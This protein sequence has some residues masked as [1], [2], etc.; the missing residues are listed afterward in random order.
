[1]IESGYEVRRILPGNRH[2][3]EQLDALLAKEGISR[4]GNLE[5]TIGLYDADGRLVATGSVFKNTLRCMAVDSNHQG[6]GLLNRVTSLLVEYQANRE[7][8]ELFLYTKCSTAKFFGDLGFFE[9]CRVSDQVV[10]MENRRNGFSDY[11]SKL[12]EPGAGPRRSAIIMNANPFTL[13]HRHLVERASAESDTVHLF[14]VS[15][16]ASLVPAKVRY[17]LVKEGVGDLPNVVLH[18]TGPYMI[19]SATFP[20]YFIRD[21]RDIILA[22]ARLDIQVFAHIA[23]KL[24]ITARYVGEEPFSEL[25]GLYN[26]VMRQELT[27]AGIDCVI[28]PRKEQ[29]GEAIS[30]STVRQYIQRGELERLSAMVPESTLRYFSSPEG[31]ETVVRIRQ[32]ENVVHY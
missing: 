20:S 4:D 15:E 32:A 1:M 28:I 14:V 27:A 29:G 12:G 9:I 7:I 24:M 25:T 11:L 16:D 10:F 3:A 23:K 21:S 2:A 5:Y 22:Q 19:S 8:F 17:R 6:K 31:A 18:P 30:A 26:D 13:G